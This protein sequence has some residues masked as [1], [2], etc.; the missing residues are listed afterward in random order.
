MSR[1]T[2]AQWT[3]ATVLVG[4]GVLIF[5]WSIGFPAALV[6]FAVVASPVFKKKSVSHQQALALTG[7]GAP[8][9]PT[10]HSEANMSQES[11]DQPNVIIYHRPGCSFCARMKM[12]L[13]EVSDKAV[14]VDIW[15]DPEAAEFVRSVNNG[16]ETVPTGVIDGEAHTNPAPDMVRQAL[17]PA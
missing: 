12:A 11:S 16:N 10:T 5:V 7:I 17:V 1:S 8:T 15:D 6:G 13:R 14:W 3:N 4:L 9:Q 2:R